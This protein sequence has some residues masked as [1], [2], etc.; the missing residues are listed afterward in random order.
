MWTVAK[1]ILMAVYIAVALPTGLVSLW[2]LTNA[3]TRVGIVL[4]L[5]GLTVVSLP[6]T[7]WF[8]SYLPRNGAVWSWISLVL[9]VSLFGLLT[10]ILWRTPSGQPPLDSP[11]QH[12]FT[13]ATTFQPYTVTNI[14]PEIEQINLGFLVMS[15]LDPI[16]T[17]EQA[18]RVLVPTLNVYRE[19]ERDPNFHDLG[20]VMGWAYAELLRQPYDVGHYY[21]Y[22]PKNRP[23]EPLPVILFLHGSAGNFKAYF[24]LWSKLAEELGLVIVAP[25][26]GFGNWRPPAGIAS[27]LA[28]LDDAARLVEIDPSRVYLAGL[29]NGGIAVSRIA[30]QFPERFQGLIYI[31]PVM[32]P[33]IVDAEPF[34]TAWRER[35]ILVITGAADRRISIDYVDQRVAAL[36]NGAVKVTR[37]VYP[38]EDHFLFFSR[39]DSVL[40]DISVWLS[41]AD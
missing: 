13:Q 3:A 34:L 9:S 27:P 29:S 19:M 41:S 25:S 18:S 32:P 31:S 21:L 12:R 15:Y 37:I 11:A 4:A 20:S 33:H 30:R 6:L 7:L 40:D 22:I 26:F 2:L 36:E 14:V 5:L 16:L 23:S 17:P 8:R 39:P 28:A 1:L 35:P 24:W 38:T 10:F